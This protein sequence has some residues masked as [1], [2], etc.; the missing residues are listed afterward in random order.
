MREL[1][2][3][4]QALADET[5]WRLLCL[6][7]GGPMCVCELADILEMPQSS[8]SSHLQII[9]RAGLLESERCGKWVY[10]LVAPAHRPFL[11]R[12]AET[13]RATP[14]DDPILRSDA[15]K[16][17]VRIARREDSCCPLPRRLSTAPLGEVC[18][19]T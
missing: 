12:I 10:Y 17:A 8:V 9:R 16:A 11:S 4:S 1:V 18:R 5:R 6:L 2:R 3:V 15:L 13:F 14:G 7:T 19:P